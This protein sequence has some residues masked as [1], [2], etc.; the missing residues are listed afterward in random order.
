MSNDNFILRGDEIENLIPLNLGEVVKLLLETH[1]DKVLQV[2]ADTGETYTAKYILTKATRLARWLNSKNLRP[3][4]AVSIIS[5]NR[6]EF[7]IVLCA[8][9]LSGVS[10]APFNPEYTSD[11]LQHTLNLSKPKLVFT[12]PHS[13]NRIVSIAGA[14]PF[15]KD[16]VVF[17]RHPP[18]QHSM[19]ISLDIALEAKFLDTLESE[20]FEPPEVDADDTVATILCSSGT[21]GMPK[22]VMTTQKN[23]VT[24]MSLMRQITTF[25]IHE[26][27]TT[28]VTIGIVPFFH[29]MGLMIMTLA[30]LGGRNLIIIKKFNL[31][32]FLQVIQDYKVSLVNVP[33]PIVVL[34]CQSPLVNEFDLS[35]V[36]E[37][38][39]GAAP[40]ANEFEKRIMQKF[41]LKQVGQAYGMTETTL[42]VCF[43]PPNNYKEGSVGR[44]VP[45][46][47]AKVI[48]ES[49]RALGPNCEGELCFKGP[50]IM[51]GYINDPVATSNT[52]DVDG[53]LHTG[54]VGY[55]DADGFFFVVDRIKELIKYKAYQVPPAELESIL[56]SHPDVV[57]AAVVG[58]PDDNA[59]ELPLG[60]VVVHSN[61]KVTSEDLQNYVKGKVSPQKQL[62]GGVRFIEEIPRNPS[63]KILRRVLKK[64]A[65]QLKSKL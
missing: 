29:S 15:I 49:G 44:L 26:E 61:T 63:G 19:V 31:R 14:N 59:G 24:F 28:D 1:G 32:Q 62:R 16:V 2:D 6:L 21:T 46:M 48:D 33:P 22:G 13:L 51:K 27:G 58:I 3:G 30:L 37:I 42:G 50:L 52:I 10:L 53:W 8:C 34:L 12:S 23:L 39:C 40:L 57:D 56:M 5:E 54:D 18:K 35:S 60:Y 55:Y 17:G 36:K 4:D 7:S 43:I 9:F 47:Q 20:E 65:T 45:A 38:K 41:K 64:M 11:E 25:E